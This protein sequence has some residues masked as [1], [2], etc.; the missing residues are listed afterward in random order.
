MPVASRDL[1]LLEKVQ[2]DTGAHPT[3]YSK[4]TGGYVTKTKGPGINGDL[5]PPT[6]TAA[7]NEWRYTPTPPPSLRD[8]DTDF[9]LFYTAVVGKMVPTFRRNPMTQIPSIEECDTL[10]HWS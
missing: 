9:I 3:S 4:G 7:K 6:S 10:L 5:S 1:P 8:E 2:T